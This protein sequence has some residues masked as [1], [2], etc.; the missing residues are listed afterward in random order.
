M[1]ITYHQAARDDLIRQF[2]YYMIE[3]NVPEVAI[4]FREAVRT[5]V[6]A[7]S[8]QPAIAPPCILRNPELRMLRSW[9][10]AGFET[11]RLYFLL[12]NDTL[13][14]IRILHGK[15]NVRVILER[16]HSSKD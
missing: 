16:D 4:R 8:R 1:K 2:R 9:P 11:I 15:R 3:Q 6:K 13:R 5:T 14:I 10:V 12:E 7:I